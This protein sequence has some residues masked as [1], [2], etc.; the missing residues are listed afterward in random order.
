VRIPGE[1]SATVLEGRGGN[2]NI[3]TGNR[4]AF[5]DQENI[6][7]GISLGGLRSDVDDG[8]GWFREECLELARVFVVSITAE[9]STA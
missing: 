2:P 9:E 6:D 7:F 5:R 1:E 3:V 8:D 4:T